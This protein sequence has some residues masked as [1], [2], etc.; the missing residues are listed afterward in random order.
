MDLKNFDAWAL[1]ELATW[2]RRVGDE[3]PLPATDIPAPR[4]AE[5]RGD[6]AAAA[7]EWE[8]LG[9]PYEA[10]LALVQARGVAGETAFARAVSLFEGMEARPAATRAR[11]T[12]RH[13]GATADLPAP[14]R[15]KYAVARR[16]HPLGLTKRECEVLGLVAEGVGNQEIAARLFRSTRTVENHVAAVLAKLNAANRM[17]AALRVQSEPWLISAGSSAAPAKK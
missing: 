12:A 6:I 14:R 9:L 4:A 7:D 15:G 13:A 2:R 5:L 10:A 11:Q 1:G 8:R 3:G 16:R 17:E